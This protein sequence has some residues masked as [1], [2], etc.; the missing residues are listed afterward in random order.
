MMVYRSMGEYGYLSGD[1]GGDDS[2]IGDLR[3]DYNLFGDLG[4]TDCAGD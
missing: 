3:E 1:P 4:D 2:L